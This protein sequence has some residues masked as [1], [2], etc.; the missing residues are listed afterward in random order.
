MASSQ[1]PDTLTGS[2][3]PFLVI[4]YELRRLTRLYFRHLNYGQQD[5]LRES[6]KLLK[7][8]NE[9]IDWETLDDYL[10][11]KLSTL[12]P[13]IEVTLEPLPDEV[14]DLLHDWIRKFRAV[15]NRYHSFS[16]ED[17]REIQFLTRRFIDWGIWLHTV[18]HRYHDY[19]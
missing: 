17:R 14:P 19:Q 2:P 4:L 18:K 9:M 1:N 3:E 13:G 5:F 7:E 15:Y 10:C 8:D 11:Y 12:P 6:V 16:V